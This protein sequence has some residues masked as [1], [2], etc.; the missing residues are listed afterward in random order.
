MKHLTSCMA[1]LIV[2]ITPH[3]SAQEFYAE[4]SNLT[5]GFTKNLLTK[6]PGTGL[7]ARAFYI[8]DSDANTKNPAL[9]GVLSAVVPGLGSFYAGSTGHGIRHLAAVPL[10]IGVTTLGLKGANKDEGEAEAAEL[11]I[12]A[13]GIGL[14][15]ANSVWSVVSAVSDVNEYNHKLSIG[16]LEFH[17]ALRP[18]T[19]SM[20]GLEIARIR[21]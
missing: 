7:H 19:N 6:E 12:L 2:I 17:L 18:L 15:L 16:R 9:A 10:I 5:V 13:G 3:A 4:A 11:L 14:L 20:V 21:F 1:V 8:L